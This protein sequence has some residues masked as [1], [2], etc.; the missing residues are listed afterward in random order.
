MDWQKCSG[1]KRSYLALTMVSIFLSQFG[2]PLP[3]T[4]EGMIFMALLCR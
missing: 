1:I 4:E 3:E 2:V